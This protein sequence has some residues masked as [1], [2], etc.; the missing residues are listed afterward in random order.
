MS[1]LVTN[2]AYGNGPYL[3]TT[4]LAIAFN[5]ELENGGQRRLGIIIP[6]VYGEKQ[7][8]IMLEEFGDR[9]RQ[10]PEEFFLDVNLG[11]ILKNI[12][13]GSKGTYEES[14]RIWVDNFQKAS[15]AA[16]AHLSGKFVA[17]TFFGDRTEID[18]KDIVLEINRSPRVTYGVASSLFTSFAYLT[19]IFEKAIDVKEISIDP[20]LLNKAIGVA[21]RIERSQYARFIAYPATFSYSEYYQPCY[22]QE[23]LTPPIMS[24]PKGERL[25]A[26]K[27]V[28]VTVS[29]IPGLEKLYGEAGKLGLKLYSNDPQAISG[30]EKAHPNI[31]ASGNILFHFARSGW[32]SVWSSMFLGTPLLI[33]EFDSSDDP[34]IYFNNLAIEKMGVGLIYRGQSLAQLLRAAERMKINNQKIKEKILSQFGTLDGN[35][36]CGQKFVE[37]FLKQ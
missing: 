1:Y 24:F 35:Q 25:N 2:F 29:G 4:E 27:G 8:R 37:S 32:G 23:I 36:Y 21:R 30:S 10:H 6:W 7:K 12:F 15:D 14:L 26:E 22:F 19:E 16:R 13:Y 31:M 33:P 18:G 28:F 11:N 5:D 9:I 34:E 17:E 3:R 20:S